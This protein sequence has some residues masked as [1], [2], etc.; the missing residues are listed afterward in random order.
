MNLST[1]I[2]ETK[3]ILDNSIGTAASADSR[4]VPLL[5]CALLANQIVIMEALQEI[6][7]RLPRQRSMGCGPG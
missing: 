5:V 3:E 4:T 1:N 7:D 2:K 6:Y